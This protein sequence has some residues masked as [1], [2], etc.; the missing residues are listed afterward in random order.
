[1]NRKMGWLWFYEVWA[2]MDMFNYRFDN[3]YEKIQSYQN[4]ARIFIDEFPEQEIL[5]ESWFANRLDW[6]SIQ[7]NEL[8]FQQ[9]FNNTFYKRN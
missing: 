9:H 2:R 1:M 7:G 5:R 3:G 8:S 4:K 6:I